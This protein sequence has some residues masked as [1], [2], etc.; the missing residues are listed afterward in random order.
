MGRAITM[1]TDIDTLKT[2]ISGIL[3]S[4]KTIEKELTGLSKLQGIVD[5]ANKN[6]TKPKSKTSKKG[7]N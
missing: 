1:E 5:D 3:S 6:K 4:I 2:Q 7:G